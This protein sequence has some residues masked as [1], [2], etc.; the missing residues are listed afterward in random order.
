MKQR[1]TSAYVKLLCTIII[2]AA[3]IQ[4]AFAMQDLKVQMETAIK[5][6][7]SDENALTCLDSSQDACSKAVDTALDTCG[8]LFPKG[9][10]QG[11]D[12][13]ALNAHGQ[14]M[15]NTLPKLLSV[16]A[17]K[18]DSCMTIA[19]VESAA[20]DAQSGDLQLAAMPELQPATLPAAQH[21]GTENV[22]LPVYNNAVLMTHIHDEQNLENL[23]PKFGVKP[24]PALTLASMDTI[25]AIAQYYR[26]HL[27][28]FKEYKIGN[29]V[30]FLENGP[31][32]FD[33]VRDVQ[34]YAS[35][36]HVN[37]ENIGA[38]PAVPP[39]SQ[40]KIEIAYRK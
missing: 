40:S 1:S 2:S 30:L 15:E 7:C 13:W 26:K 39:G 11:V 23:T 9:D 25:E 14:C 38:S 16:P 8:Q 10:L 22:T 3:L 18:I 24:L 36:P 34:L 33:W 37:I 19:S 12:D 4:A 5:N 21:I 6:M 31:E 20:L 27:N 32:D 35:T 28:E 29:S 17:G